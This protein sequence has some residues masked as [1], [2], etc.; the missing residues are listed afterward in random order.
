MELARNLL[1]PRLLT[2]GG[3]LYLAVLTRERGLRGGRERGARFSAVE[4]FGAVFKS[5]WGAQFY[6]GPGREARGIEAA[7][8]IGGR[9]WAEGDALPEMTVPRHPIEI[10]SLARTEPCSSTFKPKR[11]SISR[12]QGCFRT[13][14]VC[15]GLRSDPRSWARAGDPGIA[16][17]L[18][19][20]CSHG[21][22]LSF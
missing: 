12:I 21:L 18:A 4:A 3:G 16:C 20:L 2:L 1:D 11:E 6:Y 22:S 9:P 13:P 7:S 5:M 17:L 14:E 10:I 19:F 8:L 15:L